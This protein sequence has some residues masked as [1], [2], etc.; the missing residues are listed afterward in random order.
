M[1]IGY[2]D[3]VGVAIREPETD[4]PLIVDRYGMLAGP[5]ILQ[6]VQ[7]VT[8]RYFKIIKRCCQVNMFKSSQSTLD[9]VRWQSF[10]L[11]V[12]IER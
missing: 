1:V 8:G 3:V 7:T 12:A 2:F 4:A 11:S 9:Y 6:G 5:I 10:R